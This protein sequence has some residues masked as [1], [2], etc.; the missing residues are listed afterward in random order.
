MVA[1]EYQKQ[2]I[3]D[4]L[5]EKYRLSTSENFEF[6][7]FVV[8]VTDIQTKQSVSEILSWED[9]AVM[10]P[11]LSLILPCVDRCIKKLEEGVK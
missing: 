8:R 1:F 10:F 3:L 11:K 2:E 7:G 4:K 5:G 6:Q 9:I